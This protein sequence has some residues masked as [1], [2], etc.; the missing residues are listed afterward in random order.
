MQSDRKTMIR[1]SGFGR[2]RRGERGYNLVEV[3]IAMALLGVV[4]ISVVTLFVMGQRNVYSGKQMS[5]ATAIAGDVVED[6]ALLSVQGFYTS[7]AMDGTTA[8]SSITLL[9]E[10]YTNAFIRSTDAT[11]IASPP[12]NISGENDPDSTGP[13]TGFLTTW[14]NNIGGDTKLLDGNVTLIIRPTNPTLDATSGTI[15]AANS[16]PAATI[17]QIRVI[18][19]WKEGLRERHVAL[20]TVRIRR[21]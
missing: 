9:D 18:V 7:F 12:G 17:L 3:L 4:L 20:D 14:T 15:V 2:F 16:T 19:T 6:L 1:R 5:I 8:P 10:T 13:L 21:S 11:I